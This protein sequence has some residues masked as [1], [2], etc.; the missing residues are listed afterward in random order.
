MKVDKATRQRAYDALTKPV[1]KD[2]NGNYLTTL[3]KY[4]REN[5]MEFMENV[6]ILYSL[7]DG[8]KNIESLTK[9]K[10]QAGLKKGFAAIENVLNTT[11]RNSDGSLNL[12]NAALDESEREKWTLAM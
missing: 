9:G 12:G 5:P 3:Q 8:F 2:E 1:F 6:A 11:K 4:Q 10:V 7:T